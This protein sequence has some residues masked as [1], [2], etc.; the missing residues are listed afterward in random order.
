M[1]INADL[2]FGIYENHLQLFNHITLIGNQ[3]IYQSRGLSINNHSPTLLIEIV[4]YTKSHTTLFC[5]EHRYV[6]FPI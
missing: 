5:E 4:K 1:Y 6:T 3:I 2:T